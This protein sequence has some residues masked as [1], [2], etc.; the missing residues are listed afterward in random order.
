VDTVPFFVIVRVAA[1]A[2]VMLFL[3]VRGA[4]AL[5]LYRRALPG[6]DRVALAF[7]SATALPLV[8]AITTLGAEEGH[9]RAL[10][11][12]ALVGGA[13]VSTLAFPFAGPAL[14]R[15]TVAAAVPRAPHADEAGEAVP[16]S[17]PR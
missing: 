6:R 14:R 12:A 13:L 1:V 15:T 8:V 5:V 4:P 3:V 9:T 2:A 11:A 7:F 17:S 10:T 16:A